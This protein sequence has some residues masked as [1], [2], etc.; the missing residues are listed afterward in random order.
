MP[1]AAVSGEGQFSPRR[2]SG[3]GALAVQLWLLQLPHWSKNLA[4]PRGAPRSGAPRAGLT[5]S[6]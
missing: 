1:S 2:L 3:A 5:L 4:R 6:T